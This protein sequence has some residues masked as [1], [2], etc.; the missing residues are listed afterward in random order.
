MCPERVTPSRGFVLPAAIFL[1]VIMATLAAFL[2]QVTVASQL[3]SGQ[4]IQGVRAYQAARLGVESGLYAV[5]QLN[6]SCP[7]S[8]TLSGVTGLNG[9]KV[10]WTCSSTPFNEAALPHTIYQITSTA[11]TT[12][13]ASCPSATASEMQSSDYV[14][15]QLVVTTERCPSC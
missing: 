9:F 10:T 8:T 15:R 14:E 11:C 6:G 2:V 4:D 7:A 1:L 3:G 13:G 5:Q 12:T